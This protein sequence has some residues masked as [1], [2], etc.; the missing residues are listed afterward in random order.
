MTSLDA[1]FLYLEKKECPLHIGSTSVFDGEVTLDE[2]KKHIDDRIHLIP[3]YTQQVVPDPF[4]IAHPTWE[5]DE[6]FDIDNH[7]FEVE[8][9]SPLTEEELCVVAGEKLSGVMDRS[10]PLWELFLI[11]KLEGGKS[12]LIRSIDSSVM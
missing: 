11:P 1:T 3:R 9:D 2:L 8:S 4:N 5:E 12:A 10:K 6:D 7:I